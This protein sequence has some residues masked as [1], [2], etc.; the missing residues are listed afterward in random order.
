MKLRIGP[1][2]F[3]V[4]VRRDPDLGWHAKIYGQQ[5]SSPDL[6]LVR[7]GGYLRSRRAASLGDLSHSWCRGDRS[8]RA[9]PRTT[10]PAA[11]SGDNM[12][13]GDSMSKKKPTKSAKMKKTDTK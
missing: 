7:P 6:V 1:S 3:K 5:L 13:K 2:D 8:A 9:T 10:G 4:T 11:Q 12:A